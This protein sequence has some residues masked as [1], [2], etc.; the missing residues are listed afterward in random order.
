MLI[1]VDYLFFALRWLDTI[2]STLQRKTDLCIPQKETARP[3]SPDFH[4]HV[5][6]SDL[7]IP[8]IGPPIFLQQ[9][10]PFLGIFVSNFWFSVFAL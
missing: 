2:A 8:M 1:L 3:L 4:I 5:S 10:R 7:F 9:N 6:V